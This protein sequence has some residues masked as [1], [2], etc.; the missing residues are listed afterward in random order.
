MRRVASDGKVVV[1][2]VRFT[3]TYVLRGGRWL[4]VDQHSSLATR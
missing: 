1:T 4:I 2:S 3:M